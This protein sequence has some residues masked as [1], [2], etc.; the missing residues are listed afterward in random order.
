[1]LAYCKRLS[2]SNHELIRGKDELRPSDEVEHR[3]VSSLSHELRTPLNAVIGFSELMLDG[4]SG[5]LSDIQ[6]EHLGIIHTSAEHMLTL[7]NDILDQAR[8]QSGHIRLAPQPIEPADLVAECVSSLRQIAADNEVTI[9]FDRAP[10]GTARLD[11][12]RLRQVV[13]NFLSNAIKF[14][15]R[16]GTVTI[17]LMRERGRVLLEVTDTGPGIAPADQERVFE[18]FMSLPGPARDGTG[19]GLAVTK[20]IVES[21]GGQV[22]VRSVVGG[23]STFFAWLPVTPASRNE[24]P[25]ALVPTGGRPRTR[26]TAARSPRRAVAQ[27]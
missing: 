22:G 18:A 13:L 16:R 24:P 19:L 6:H 1:M 15:G 21:Q 7:I 23:G 14:T 27:R 11:P 8:L 26:P 5:P 12:A 17:G 3:L 25:L 9:D 10:I 2:D 20:L 4:R